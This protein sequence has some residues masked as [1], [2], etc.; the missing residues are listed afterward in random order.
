M[1]TTHHLALPLIEAAQAQK[2][3]THNEALRALDSLVQLAVID[4]D[5][6]APPGAPAEGDR[7]IVQASPPPSG[8]W[9]GRGNHVAAWQDGAWRFCA[10]QAGWVAYAID[11]GTL[12]TWSGSAWGDFFATVTALQNLARLGL[13]TTADAT[14]PFA[15]KLN[16]ALWVAKTVAEGGDGDLRTKLS[17]ESAADTL[18]LLFQ[19]ALSGRAEIGL[20]GDDDFHFKVSADGATWR[21]GL[22]LD[23]L[24][25]R[26]SFPSGGAREQ[27]TAARTY[28][29]RTDG[30]DANSGLVNSAGGA[31]LT[32]QKAYDVIDATLDL[33][34][35]TVTIQ[36]GDGAYAAGLLVAQPWTGGGAVV[37]QGNAGAPANVHISTASGSLGGLKVTAPLPGLITIKD[38]KITASNIVALWASAPGTLRFSNLVFGATASFHI[39]ADAP[40][41]NIVASGNYEIV[42]GASAGHAIANGQGRIVCA[43]ITVTLT[44]TPAFGVFANGGR[45]GFVSFEAVTFIGGATGPRYIADVNGVVYVGGAG[46]TFLPGTTAGT[47]ANGGQY[48]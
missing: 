11:E 42:G 45:L 7:Y 26:V 6:G 12:L 47:V 9:A 15:A 21:E 41:A 37:I 28:Y 35:F 31:F 22:K 38:L 32:L 30:S 1:T 27:L 4:R 13:G 10:P 25:G 19:T 48:V 2:H 24:T 23:R 3:V 17:K 44:G 8:A 39:A 16:N 18:S 14:N 36:L 34:G 20:T 46:A 40:G 43:S 5:L 33:A 29:V